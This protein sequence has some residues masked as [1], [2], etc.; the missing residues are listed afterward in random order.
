MS[1]EI[2]QDTEEKEDWRIT[3]EDEPIVL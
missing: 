2:E 3:E 1:E